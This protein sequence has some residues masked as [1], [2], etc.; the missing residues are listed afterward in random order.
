M[1]FIGGMLQALILFGLYLF[2][3]AWVLSNPIL[4]GGTIVILA[5]GV[6]IYIRESNE[7]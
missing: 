4:V 6:V 7:V 5:V 3:L 2:V 1:Q